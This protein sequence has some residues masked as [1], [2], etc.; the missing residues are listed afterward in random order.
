[1]STSLLSFRSSKASL[2]HSSKGSRTQLTPDSSLGSSSLGRSQRVDDTVQLSAQRKAELLELMH[3]TE[4]KV[5]SSMLGNARSLTLWKPR[6]RKKGIDYYV[7]ESVGKGLSRF[8]CVGQTDAS[9]ADLMSMFTVSNTETLLKNVRVMYRNVQEAKILS[10]LQPATRSHPSR[11]VYIRYASFDTPMPM[12]GRD[13]CVC[14]CTNVIEMADGSTVG[15]CL[16]DSVDIP[17]CPDR[18]A[19]DKIIRSKM[20]HSGFV[21]R[22]SEEP[23]AVTKVC[24]LIGVE[25]KGFAPQLTGRIHMRIFGDNCRRVCEH[26]R[27]RFRE[28]ETFTPREQWTPKSEADACYVCSGPFKLL[29]KKYNCVRCGDV[30][31]RHCYFMEEVSVRGA[32]VTRVRICQKCLEDNGLL[33]GHLRAITARDSL[34]S[35][36]SDGSGVRDLLRD[37]SASSRN[38]PFGLT[39]EN[40]GRG[41]T[42]YP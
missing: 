27:K 2:G 35:L 18:F 41:F 1:M 21:F 19:T 11:S 28:P 4:R 25:I 26:Y 12:N 14:V 16:W 10:V 33:A 6:M 3:D 24:Y 5:V 37:N 30:V 40:Y 29:M 9:V 34:D 13:I 8:C 20:W 22:N 23:N 42:C 38:Y 17:E 31:C 15:Y 39:R 7:D 36:N 32:G